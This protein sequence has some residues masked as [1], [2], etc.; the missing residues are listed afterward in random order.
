L[1]SRFI[2][3]SSLP[4]CGGCGHHL[5]AKGTEK[6]LERLGL[7]PLDVVLVT[8]IGCHGIIDANFTTHTVHGLHGRSVA[9]AAGIAASLP[10]GKKVL[11]YTG[12][13]GA[14][15]G[16]QHLM[17]AALRNFDVTVIVHNNMLYGMTGGQPSSVTPC[18]FR[19]PTCP[20]GKEGRGMDLC[21]RVHAAGAM[22]SRRVLGK[23][24]ISEAVAEA[25]ATPGFSL[26]EVV[27]YC[28][29]YGVKHNP[30]RSLEDIV[31]DAGLAL[32]TLTN[33]AAPV[34][35]LEAGTPSESLLDL[36]PVPRRFTSSLENRVSILLAGSAGEGVQV[37]AEMLARAA[38][39]CGLSATKKGAYPVTVGVGHSVAELILSPQPI[40]HTAAEAPDF[41]VVTSADGLK[42]CG[43]SLSK[44]RSGHL[45]LDAG[46][47]APETGA[48]L[49]SV[50]FRQAA[51]PKSAAISALGVLLREHG[52]IPL[53]AL[54]AEAGRG[55]T[56][57]RADLERLLSDTPPN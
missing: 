37:A 16:L 27:E 36:E 53:A 33:P 29:S 15:I 8:D 39:S 18:G 11:A 57:G 48:R 51:G 25:V 19:T 55:R 3:V 54:R 38:I 26:L 10:E 14:V 42:Y 13:G 46:L 20:D 17:E 23:G 49:T 9:L 5:V 24:D 40:L 31:S 1:N 22:W 12:D 45:L 7:A 34:C 28:P 50:N 52:L 2:A 47:A 6:A 35:R 56:A 41:V 44:M 32:E 43:T 30:G 4:F 21:R